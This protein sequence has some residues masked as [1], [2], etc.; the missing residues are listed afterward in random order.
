[1]N[2]SVMAKDAYLFAP[3]T[4]RAFGEAPG[5]EISEGQGTFAARNPPYGADIAYRL[6]DGTA[7]DT[8]RIVITNMKGDTITTLNGRGGAG[9][10]RVTWD[11]AG[12]PPKGKPLTPAGRRDS[13]ITAGKI[14]HVLDSLEKAGTATKAELAI[15]RDHIDKNTLFDLLGGAGGGGGAGGRNTERAAEGAMPRGMAGAGRR[16][17]AADTTKRAAGDTSKMAGAPGAGGGA[18]APEPAVSEAVAREVLTALRA[19]KALPGGGF[20]GRRGGGPVETGDY[21]VTMTWKGNSQHQVLR[22]ENLVGNGTPMA[23][24]DNEDPFDP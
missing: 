10:H 7:K 4:A 3:R 16:G 24:E 1:M 2:D 23:P 11:L 13:L 6:S 14:D 18:G 20:G 22:V 8:V 15:I 17:G 12:K 9:M 5:A 21:M 19:A